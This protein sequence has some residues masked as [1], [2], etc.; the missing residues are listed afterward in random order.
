MHCFYPS[1][2]CY[3]LDMFS[4]SIRY[5]TSRL[6]EISIF[7]VNLNLMFYKQHGEL[8]INF[9]NNIKIC[10]MYVLYITSLYTF[11]ECQDYLKMYKNYHVSCKHK[12]VFQSVNRS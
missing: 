9:N 3:C 1:N 11:N 5:F 2:I 10:I 4:V 8:I 12:W 7:S 6:S